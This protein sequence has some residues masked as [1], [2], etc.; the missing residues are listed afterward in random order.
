MTPALVPRLLIKIIYSLEKS[1]PNQLA[2]LL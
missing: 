2:I 1:I